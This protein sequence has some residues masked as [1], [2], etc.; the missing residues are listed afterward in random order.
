MQGIHKK[1][2]DGAP[3]SRQAHWIYR[4]Y[5]CEVRALCFKYPFCVLGITGKA[6][7]EK[8]GKTLGLDEGLI[9]A[10]LDG[11]INERTRRQSIQSIRRNDFASQRQIARFDDQSSLS[12]S[13]E[14]V[15]NIS[16][17]TDADERSED[18]MHGP[19][20]GE[21]TGTRDEGLRRNFGSTPPRQLSSRSS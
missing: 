17:N 1:D 14:P 18:E 20:N 8:R 7:R 21:D 15:I 3:Q 6:I 13:A 4:L 10:E 5:T 11:M 2:M 19:S 16:D 9:I 12:L